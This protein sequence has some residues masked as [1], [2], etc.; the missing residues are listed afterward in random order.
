MS[1]KDL[2]KS[3]KNRNTIEITIPF[4]GAISE[5]NLGSNS[6]NDEDSRKRQNGDQTDDENPKERRMSSK[7]DDCD[8]SNEDS[9]KKERKGNKLDG[10]NISVDTTSKNG[11]MV[12]NISE[13]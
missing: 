1:E 2:E 11:Q 10:S 4:N 12:I 9:S 7:A 6:S 5:T 13:K 3:E 8:F